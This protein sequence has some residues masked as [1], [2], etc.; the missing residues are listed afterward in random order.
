QAGASHF[1]GAIGEAADESLHSWWLRQNELHRCR[2]RH[3]CR[4]LARAASRLPDPNQRGIGTSIDL[5]QAR[6]D[7]EQPGQ[8][9]QMGSRLR[10]A[11]AIDRLRSGAEQEAYRARA[12]TLS[13]LIAGL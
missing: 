8:W 9:D 5:S 3:H 1:W 7:E 6:P 12:A 13:E 10:V 11:P 4:V 2:G